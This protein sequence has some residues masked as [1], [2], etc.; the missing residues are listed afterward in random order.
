LQGDGTAFLFLQDELRNAF[1]STVIDLPRHMLI[2]NPALMEAVNVAVVV[3]E[4]TLAATRDTI[5][6]LAWLKANAPKTRVL[7]VANK[8]Q[9]GHGEEIQVKD[10]EASIERKI[11][12]SIPYDGKV[13]VQA[14]KLGK[15]FLD[16]AK[17]SKTGAAFESLLPLLLGESKA[18]TGNR[19]LIE[20][21]GGLAALFKKP[22]APAPAP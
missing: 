1:G 20:Q 16:V 3:T 19:S 15:A 17:G 2:Q 14:A 21:L 5:R 9:T 13:A 10:F 7:L 8:A 18:A 6:L 12:V 4:L 22:T 11:D